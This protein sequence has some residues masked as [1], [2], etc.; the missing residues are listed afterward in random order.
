MINSPSPAVQPEPQ[1]SIPD[2]SGIGEPADTENNWSADNNTEAS[3]LAAA[4]DDVSGASVTAGSGGGSNISAPTPPP[5]KTIE[6]TKPPA[7]T[8]KPSAAPSV[9]AS[10]VSEAERVRNDKG[11]TE[12]YTN[13]ESKQ[14]DDASVVSFAV[15]DKEFYDNVINSSFADRSKI[16]ENGDVVLYLTAS[17]FADFTKVLRESEIDYTLMVL[18][19]NDDVKVIMT[20]PENK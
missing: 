16:E 7:P 6:P 3:M 5:A 15:K 10:P 9:S 11:E 20:V 19:K 17:E 4:S 18:G 1:I 12:L 8:A 14:I 2:V 13:I